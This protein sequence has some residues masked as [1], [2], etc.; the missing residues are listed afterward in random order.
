MRS[1]CP[2]KVERAAALLEFLLAFGVFFL[3]LIAVLD[4][5]LLLYHGSLLRSVTAAAAQQTARTGKAILL[6]SSLKNELEQHARD[7][8]TAKLFFNHISGA[9]IFHGYVSA[10]SGELDPVTLRLDG[11]WT[12]SCILCSGFFPMTLAASAT[13][14]FEPQGEIECDATG[15][16]RQGKN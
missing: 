6:E 1:R 8:L 11:F 13:V 12:R 14:I 3:L 2:E 4:A 7:A 16:A 10:C 15:A 9:L 5:G